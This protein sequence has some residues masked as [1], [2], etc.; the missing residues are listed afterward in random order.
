MVHFLLHCYLIEGRVLQSF[1][2]KFPLS[3]VTTC[4]KRCGENNS[5]ESMKNREYLLE[6]EIR[7][8]FKYWVMGLEGV[9][10]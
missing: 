4:S 6:F 5:G 1:E 8:A 2:N 9:H 7:K 3:T 10:L